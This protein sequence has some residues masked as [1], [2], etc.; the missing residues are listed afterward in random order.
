MKK[1][2][3]IN[4]ICNYFNLSESNKTDLQTFLKENESLPDNEFMVKLK[5]EFQ[6]IDFAFKLNEITLLK[7]ISNNTKSTKINTGIILA[8]LII[9]LLLFLKSLSDLKLL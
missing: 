6:W 5:Q 1:E 4:A 7:E 8:I 2:S 3:Q 9:V